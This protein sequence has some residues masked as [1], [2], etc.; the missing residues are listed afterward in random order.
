MHW[1]SSKKNSDVNQTLDRMAKAV[2]PEMS[3][4]ARLGFAKT[5]RDEP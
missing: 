1:G 2:I 3:R 5:F 4:K